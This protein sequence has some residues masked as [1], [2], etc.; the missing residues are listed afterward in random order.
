ML[1]I[2][3]ILVKPKKPRTM[4]LDRSN[5]SET[6]QI[7]GASSVTAGNDV[8]KKRAHRS[9]VEAIAKQSHC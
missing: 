5:D 8:L 9:N 2:G 6:S 3:F 1:Q 4:L 7:L